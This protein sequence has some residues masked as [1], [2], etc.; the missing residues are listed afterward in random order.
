MGPPTSHLQLYSRLWGICFGRPD[1]WLPSCWGALVITR[2]ME[3]GA[4]ARWNMWHSRDMGDNA[5]PIRPNALIWRVNGVEGDIDLMS[6]ELCAEDGRRRL[7]LAITNPATYA[8]TT[9]DGFIKRAGPGILKVG[10]PAPTIGAIGVP[11]P[12]AGVGMLALPPLPQLPQTLW[13]KRPS[14]AEREAGPPQPPQPP[15]PQ[16]GRRGRSPQATAAIGDLRRAA[17]E[18]AAHTA[19]AASLGDIPRLAPS[20]PHAPPPGGVRAQQNL[21]ALPMLPSVPHSQRPPSMAPLPALPDI[22]Q[23]LSTLALAPPPPM[24]G[25]AGHK[26]PPGRPLTPGEMPAARAGPPPKAPRQPRVGYRAIAAA[27]R[28][29][30]EQ[31]LP[32]PRMQPP[33]PDPPG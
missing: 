18:D 17:L 27:T 24:L 11:A 9:K 8:F 19:H 3:G 31:G 12:K 25:K 22:P 10:A 13:F 23:H 30:R 2:I 32:D 16:R 15:S 14:T 7:Q 29:A 26:P 21:P 33:S 5:R 4:L 28:A 1:D 6:Q 20:P